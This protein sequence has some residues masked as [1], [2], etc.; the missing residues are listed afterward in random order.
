[1]DQRNCRRL[2]GEQ[3]TRLPARRSPLSPLKG[4]IVQKTL[5]SGHTT[6]RTAGLVAEF[7]VDGVNP[8]LTVQRSKRWR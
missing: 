8:D 4:R 7:V 5:G 2:I 6:R 3:A 1:M